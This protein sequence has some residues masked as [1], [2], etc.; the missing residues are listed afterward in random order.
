MHDTKAHR[1]VAL[2]ILILFSALTYMLNNPRVRQADVDVARI[3]NGLPSWLIYPLQVID[4][5]GS[6][7]AW[8]VI[9]ALVAV[10]PRFGK[11][12]A[13][14]LAASIVF[15]WL[16]EGVTK[17]FVQRPRPMGVDEIILR[18][19]AIGFS[20]PSGHAIRAYCGAYVITSFRKKFFI[21]LFLTA[22]G[23]AVSRV[24]LGLHYPT[25]VVGGALLGILIGIVFTGEMQDFILGK[26]RQALLLMEKFKG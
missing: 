19:S 23:V 24:Y 6:G 3:I 13:L 14:I 25:D 17:N 21:P 8:I 2:A 12:V 7:V 1:V 4:W 20:F 9:I 5:L 10:T 22:T 18:G 26:A 16:L 15:S 11:K